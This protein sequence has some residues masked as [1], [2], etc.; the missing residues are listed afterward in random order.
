M[1]KALLKYHSLYHIPQ[2]GYEKQEDMEGYQQGGGQGRMG[3]W[4]RE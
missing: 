4:Y 1:I 2:E 3:E